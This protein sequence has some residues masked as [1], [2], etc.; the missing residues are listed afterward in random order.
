MNA[1][2]EDIKRLMR[3]LK[4]MFEAH[5]KKPTEEAI[6]YYLDALTDDNHTYDEIIWAIKEC[7]KKQHYGC[8]TPGD[9]LANLQ[10]TEADK[11]SRAS[12]EAARIEYAVRNDNFEGLRDDPVTA[13]LL[14]TRYRPEVLENMTEESFKFK[15]IEFKKD[16]LNYSESGQMQEHIGLKAGLNPVNKELSEAMTQHKLT[17][18]EQD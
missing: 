2:K 6:E 14:N 3:K 8:P 12:H 16:Y 13:F 11:E 9:I 4:G 7:G 18:G 5:S 10:E 1:K 15:M 17:T